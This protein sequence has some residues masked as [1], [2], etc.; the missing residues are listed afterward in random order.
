[1]RIQ[2]AY[3]QHLTASAFIQFSSASDAFDT[4]LRIRYRF[5][6]GRDLYLVYNEA[7]D[8]DR[9]LIT[10]AFPGSTN[11]GR[12]PFSLERTLVL[13]YSHTLIR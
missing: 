11:T 12:T 2:A 9:D 3:D 10:T 5:A 13:K 6:E 7:L 4:N 8:T 1:M